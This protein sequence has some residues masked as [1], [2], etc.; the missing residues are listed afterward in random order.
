MKN[1]RVR[2][3]PKWFQ[4]FYWWGNTSD[5]DLERDKKTVVVQ[6]INNGSWSQ[7]KWLTRTYGKEAL[8]KT[9]Q[10]TPASEFR[11]GALKL[12]SLLLGINRMNYA[13]RSDYIK[14]KRNSRKTPNPS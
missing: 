11:S 7:W 13:S 1:E 14:A 8:K 6:L 12:I 5:M 3:V 10:E 9:I 4:K 2:N